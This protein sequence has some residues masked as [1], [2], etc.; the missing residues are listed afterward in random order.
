M[1]EMLTSLILEVPPDIDANETSIQTAVFGV[2][3]ATMALRENG[4]RPTVFGSSTPDISGFKYF[5]SDPGVVPV[6][7]APFA[8]AMASCFPRQCRFLTSARKVQRIFPK[9]PR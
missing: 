8:S 3:P 1:V 4:T 5:T 6:N 2:R 9:L 7:A